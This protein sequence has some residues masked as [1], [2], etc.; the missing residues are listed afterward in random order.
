MPN[1]F[2]IYGREAT[3]NPQPWT[4]TWT[5]GTNLAN[6]FA[7]YG[8]SKLADSSGDLTVS[9]AATVAATLDGPIQVAKFHNLTLGATLSVSQRCRGLM[10]LVTGNLVVN[11]GGGISM[12]GLGAKGA[13][14]W[15]IGRDIFVPTS[16][17][18]TGKNTSLAQFLAWV[19]STGYCIFDPT[20]YACPLPGMGDVQ[21]D[22]ATWTPYGSNLV[23]D[24]GCGQASSFN[25]A[26]AA[27][28]A[29]STGFSGSNA[30]G[31][32][33][34]GGAYSGGAFCSQAPGGRGYP[35][36]GGPGSGA[37]SGGLPIVNMPE[38]HCG[39]GG[40]GYA[41]GAGNPRGDGTASGVGGVLC[42][43]V[44]G[45]STINSG[46]VI[47][48]DGLSG[49]VAANVSA[50]CSGG[51]VA[52]L[53]GLGTIS[54]TG[55]LRANGGTSAGGTY[56]GGAGGAGCAETKTFAQMGWAA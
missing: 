16:I 45:T 13:A 49:G 8:Y 55:T 30:P 9:V 27:N 12:T 34:S 18:F 28:L 33:G 29:G 21:C 56:P 1:S 25:Y 19:R 23:T 24:A 54:N 22:W 4:W 46:G 11:S 39:K 6:F 44:L 43:V 2:A 26:T 51:G 32:G 42:V 5:P 37:N 3:P 17:T 40:G 50:G 31:G 14:N 52:K 41:P 20:M 15:A 47:Q 38:D 48:A 7:L 36:G 10:P 53:L 35:W